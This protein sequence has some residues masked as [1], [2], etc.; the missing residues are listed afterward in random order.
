MLS[1]TP[2]TNASTTTR[3]GRVS[4]AS[5]KRKALKTESATKEETPKVKKQKTTGGT[6]QSK[7]VIKLVFKKT[8]KPNFTYNCSEGPNCIHS[9]KSPSLSNH[10]GLAILEEKPAFEDARLRACKLRNLNLE[11]AARYYD[12]NNLH[13]DTFNLFPIAIQGCWIALR[14]QAA[15]HGCAT[16]PNHEAVDRL[17]A[18]QL[19]DLAADELETSRQELEN[20][21]LA[22]KGIQDSIV[23]T[24]AEETTEERRSRLLDFGDEFWIRW[25]T[26]VPEGLSYAQRWKAEHANPCLADSEVLAIRRKF[27]FRYMDFRKEPETGAEDG[28]LWNENE[29]VAILAGHARTEEQKEIS[30]GFNAFKKATKCFEQMEKLIACIR[31]LE[32]AR[33]QH[34]SNVNDK[35]QPVQAPTPSPSPRP[36]SKFD[37]QPLRAI[38]HHM[39]ALMGKTLTPI[40]ERFSIN[41]RTGKAII[42]DK[43]LNNIKHDKNNNK[44]R[45]FGL[46]QN[47]IRCGTGDWSLGTIYDFTKAGMDGKKGPELKRSSNLNPSQL[48]EDRMDVDVD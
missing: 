18:K 13:K 39:R 21:R 20:I 38:P 40:K 15:R 8:P 6:A 35:E 23:L 4:K 43:R 12:C 33:I 11:Y 27:I 48:V 19:S 22:E 46:N 47:M 7:K 1:D 25:A 37:V 10:W 16:L 42:D 45:V 31:T 36:N 14:Q 30:Y 5:K 3:S 28:E 17:H 32:A 9:K 24:K 26:S 2:H 29:I 34:I 44:F 41:E